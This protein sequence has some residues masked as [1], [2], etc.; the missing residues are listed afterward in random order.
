MRYDYAN[1]TAVLAS[2]TGG[3]VYIAPSYGVTGPA[4][5]EALRG[6]EIRFAAQSAT[7]LEM[8]V[9]LAF[10]MLGLNIRPVF[11]MESRGAGRLAFERG[12][13]GIDIQTTPA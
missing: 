2:P 4:D 10:E 1:W 9:L 13:S 7:G 6:A 11:G 5:I 3:V 8:P 12:E